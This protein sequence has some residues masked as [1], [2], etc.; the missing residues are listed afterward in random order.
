MFNLPA[1]D[2]SRLVGAINQANATIEPDTIN[3]APNS[4]YTLTQPVDVATGLP[5]VTS[6]IVINGNGS[7]IQRSGADGVP[8][9]RIL[10]VTAGELTLND[11]RLRN[12][13]ASSGGGVSNGGTLK[14]SNSILSG[15]EAVAPTGSGGSGGAILNSGTLVVSNSTLFRNAARIGGGIANRDFGIARVANSTI[16]G[17][18]ASF[19]AGIANSSGGIVNLLYSLLFRNASSTA[20][21]GI[22]NFS[23]AA[24]LINSTVSANTAAACGGINNEDGNVR[25]IN[26]TVALNSSGLCSFQFANADVTNS[27]IVDSVA[28]PD[29]ASDD[30]IV[31]AGSNLDSDGSCAALQTGAGTFATVT[32]AQLRLGALANNSGS[33]RTHALLQGSIAID[34]GDQAECASRGLFLDQRGALRLIDGNKDGTAVCDIGAFE[35]GARPAVCGKRPVTIFGTPAGELLRGTSGPDVIR[36]YSGQDVIVGL[37]G[38]DSICG[39]PGNDVIAGGRGDNFF[40]AGEGGSDRLIGSIGADRIFGGPDGDRLMGGPGLDQLDGG[41]GPDVC[42]AGLPAAGDTAANCETAINVP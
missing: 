14:V 19:G 37:T 32:A 34:A 29:C 33:A 31:A 9:F 11:V 10:E 30:A 2:V 18:T 24:R 25:I 39:G 15:N 36:A 8:A 38:D 41:L 35:F 22:D 23:A 7:L 42:D 6:P 12:G 13:Q 26:S 5:V 28:G 1:G 27:L 17:N 4:I 40:L 3:L 16:S 21:A 20:G